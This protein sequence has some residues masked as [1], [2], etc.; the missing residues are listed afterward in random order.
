MTNKI[1]GSDAGSLIY[2]LPLAAHLLEISGAI[3]AVLFLA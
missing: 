3:L 2:H 1:I